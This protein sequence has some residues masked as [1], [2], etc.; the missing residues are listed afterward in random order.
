MKIMLATIIGIAALAGCT[1][2]NHKPSAA[3][4]MTEPLS[5]VTHSN[6]NPIIE[7]QQ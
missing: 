7:V 3:Y 4:P 5:S 2:S 1:S 6:I